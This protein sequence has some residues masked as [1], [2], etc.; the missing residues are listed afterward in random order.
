MKINK[1]YSEIKYFT[2][3]CDNHHKNWI[4]KLNKKL[5]S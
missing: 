4:K 3:Y 5:N 1:I 2:I